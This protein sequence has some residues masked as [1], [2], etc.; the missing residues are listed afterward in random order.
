MPFAAR[1]HVLRAGVGVHAATVAT[2]ISVDPGLQP[3]AVNVIGDVGRVAIFL[4]GLDGRPLLSIY[5]DV[6]CGITLAPPPT[7]IND[8][9]LVTGSLH[10]I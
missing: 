4:A 8:N 7:F 10:A 1:I 5:D 2:C 9:V 6:A 3:Q